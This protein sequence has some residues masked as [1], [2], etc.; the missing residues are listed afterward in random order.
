MTEL[1]EL[2]SLGMLI[3]QKQY[4]CRQKYEWI[5]SI[6]SGMAFLHRN[7]V[8]HRDLKPENILVTSDHNIKISDFGTSKHADS[9]SQTMVGTSVSDFI[10][11]GKSDL[12]TWY[13][14]LFTTF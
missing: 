4:S 11:R 8:V 6:A 5:R 7:F 9:L 13:S 10:I 3:R 1:C 2:G 12:F 14:D